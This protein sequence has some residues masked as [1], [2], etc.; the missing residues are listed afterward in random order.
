M[1]RSS[2]CIWNFWMPFMP[3][4]AAKPCRGTLEVPVTNW[5]NLARSAWSNE[6]RALQN[7]WILR[8]DRFYFSFV[9][10]YSAH[11]HW[12]SGQDPEYQ[13]FD[14]TPERDPRPSTRTGP[15]RKKPAILF[16]LYPTI[17]IRPSWVCSGWSY[18][19]GAGLVL[20]VLRVG[21]EVIDVDG[22][23]TRDEQL[24]LLLSEDGDQPLG[25]DLIESFQEG[26]QL[27][28]NGTW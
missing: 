22:G 2:R 3:S 9:F 26:R 17:C 28:P 14:S 7:H 25:D 13:C 10:S 24:Q 19:D 16:N 18:L 6:R 4:S 11:L 15:Y 21:L 20:V 27:F 5:R 1:E 23:Q 12:Y 8:A